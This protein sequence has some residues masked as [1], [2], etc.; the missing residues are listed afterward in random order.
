[1]TTP[2]G[3]N[4]NK[5]ANV[6][7]PGSDREHKNGSLRS[8]PGDARLSQFGCLDRRAVVVRMAW[9]KAVESSEL[10][11]PSHLARQGAGRFAVCG[12][13][14]LLK[15]KYTPRGQCWRRQPKVS[16]VAAVRASINW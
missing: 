5:L 8:P 1:M 10:C 6:L 12:C 11:W 2:L 3:T 7:V 4:T 16:R 13:R 14:G 9:Q 15:L